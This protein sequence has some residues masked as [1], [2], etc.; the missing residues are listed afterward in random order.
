M[1]VDPFNRAI[2]PSRPVA[3][4]VEQ[5]EGRDRP[6]TIQGNGGGGRQDNGPACGTVTW[7][8]LIPAIGHARRPQLPA[9]RSD[10]GCFSAQPFENGSSDLSFWKRAPYYR[11]P[12]L[13]RQAFDTLHFGHFTATAR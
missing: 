3:H 7:V 8:A 1:P 5:E 9:A 10:L 12:N 13:P 4:S 2:A 6:K 11:R